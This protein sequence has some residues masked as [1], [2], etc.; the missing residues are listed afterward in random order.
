[1]MTPEEFLEISTA[2]T[3]GTPLTQDQALALVR[4]IQRMDLMLL[5][6]QNALNLM[7]ENAAE[8][9]PAL[10]QKVVAMCGR[11]DNKIKRKAA[12]LSAELFA[13]IEMSLQTYL[14]NAMIEGARILG[15]DLAELL[16]TEL[17]DAISEDVPAQEEEA[18]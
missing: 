9:I 16:G 2:A 1:M 10:S 18:Q 7:V 6:G 11:T 14:A 3:D 5:I 12:E 4:T 13:D 17:A 8:T 15:V